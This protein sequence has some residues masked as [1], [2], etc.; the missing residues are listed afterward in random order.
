MVCIIYVRWRIPVAVNV[1]N[2]VAG[3]IATISKFVPEVAIKAITPMFRQ[4]RGT[5]NNTHK[6]ASLISSQA[7][8]FDWAIHPGGASILQGAK[9]ALH[10]T[11]DHIRASLDVYQH[12]G[13]S[14]SPTVLIVLDK[15]RRMGEGRENVVATSFGPGL[16]I[17]MCM[18][19][20]CRHVA[21]S[22]R[23]KF[24]KHI[25]MY[26]F[27]LSLRSCLR[28]GGP[29]RQPRVMQCAEEKTSGYIPIV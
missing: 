19:R 27:W 26:A 23:S 15:L 25:K 24:G 21:A 2:T 10:L 17:E 13:N 12:C 3:M 18:M 20:R 16:T 5:L 6:V 9:E 29:R 1:A 22:P 28:K 14:S 7:S 4:L 11:D 8:G